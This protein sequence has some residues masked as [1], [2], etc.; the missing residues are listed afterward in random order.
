[1]SKIPRLTATAVIVA[2][3]TLSAG[4]Y[5]LAAA[6]PTTEVKAESESGPAATAEPT[7]EASPDP[8][9]GP[10]PAPDPKKEKK[11]KKPGRWAESGRPPGK[12]ISNRW[13]FYVGGYAADV[14]TTASIGSGKLLG[15]TIRVEDDLG[16]GSDDRTIRA[17]GFYRFN[18][19]HGLD[20]GY[21]A[22]SRNGQNIIDED[23]EFQDKIFSV[24]AD[25]RTEFDTSWIRLAYKYSMVNNQR[26]EAGITA[27]FSTYR[28]KLALAGEAA[29]VDPNGV[30]GSIAFDT[31]EESIFVP[32]PTFGFFLTYAMRPRLLFK[33][34]A[35]LLDLHAGDLEG[36]VLDT[37]IGVEW[38]F[39]EH[40]G[41]G[42]LSNTMDIDVK[43]TGDNPWNIE[44]KQRGWVA[45]VTFVFG[46]NIDKKKPRILG[47]LVP[48]EG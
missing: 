31:V 42:L 13:G 17:E 44:Y 3:V 39:S 26:A 47:T 41:V 29:F 14:N 32:V 28:F 18:P 38:Y 25:I 11:E 10:E 30:V 6:D 45:Y 8:A 7:G 46:S 16:L 5:G 19:R 22:L 12:I 9:P 40:A 15:T 20:F 33:L 2:L 1:M 36:T 27:G 21:W 43:D 4:Q 23:I 34:K 37:T 48:T 24:G 35:D